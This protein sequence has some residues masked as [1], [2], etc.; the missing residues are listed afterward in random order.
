MVALRVTLLGGFE[1]RLASGAPLSLPTRKAQALLAYLSVRPGQG[2]PR[3]KLAALL[4]SEKRDDQAR[5]GLRQALLVLRRALASPA[6]RVL[7]SE[8]HALAL[9]PG[10]VE[11]DVAAFTGQG[12]C[13]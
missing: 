1:A 3:D 4:W 12:R 9:D 7:R 13:Q 11:V 2:H 8:G 6:A 5:S 10:G